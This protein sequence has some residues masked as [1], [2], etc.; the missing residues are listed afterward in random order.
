VYCNFGTQSS[1]YFGVPG[2]LLAIAEAFQD[3]PN[4][5]LVIAAGWAADLV[6]TTAAN[7][8]VVRTA[9]QLDLLGRAALIV[10]HGGL[11][12]IKEAIL[13][14]TPMI[15]IPFLHDQPANARRVAYHGLGYICWPENCTPERVRELT[16]KALADGQVRLNLKRMSAIFRMHES[17]GFTACFVNS[18]LRHRRG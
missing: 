7:V 8:V 5:Q 6:T 2:I 4:C 18:L 9:P 1:E 10:T 3:L 14:E 15:V 11:G 12:T 16:S 17:E 13:A